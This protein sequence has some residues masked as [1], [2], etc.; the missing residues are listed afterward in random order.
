MNGTNNGGSDN[1]ANGRNYPN[2][3]DN[4]WHNQPGQPHPGQQTNQPGQ[5]QQPTQPGQYYSARPTQPTQPSQQ[6]PA[7]PGQPPHQW[8]HQPPTTPPATE[9]KKKT[10]L[11][12]IGALLA[13]L[14]L[15]IA[16]G[17]YVVTQTGIGQKLAEMSYIA[18]A[19]PGPEAFMDTVVNDDSAD[20]VQSAEIPEGRLAGGVDGS[21]DNLYGGTGELSTCDAAALL[22]HLNANDELNTAFAEGIGINADDVERYVNALSPLV[23]MQDTWVTNHGFNNGHA[24]PFQAVL[25]RGTAVLVDAKGVPRVR[26]ACGNPLAEAWN[27]YTA[28]S[29]NNTAWDGY[30]PGNVVAVYDAGE[31]QKQLKIRDL[32]TGSAEDYAISDDKIDAQTKVTDAVTDDTPKTVPSDMDVKPDEELLNTLGMKPAENGDARPTGGERF[33]TGN[34]SFDP[35]AEAKPE[36]KTTEVDAAAFETNPNIFYIPFEGQ[37]GWCLAK[38][39]TDDFS[40]LCSPKA[41]STDLKASFTGNSLDIAAA[42][43]SQVVYKTG[44]GRFESGSTAHPSGPGGLRGEPTYLKEG[45]SVTIR[46]FTCYNLSDRIR[47]EGPGSQFDAIDDD[48]LYIDESPEKVGATCGEVEITAS[49]RTVTVRVANGFVDC[50]EAMEIAEKYVNSPNDGTYGQRNIQTIDNWGCAYRSLRDS[51]E[52][53]WSGNCTS[54]DTGGTFVLQ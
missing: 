31:S 27:G 47:C 17:I 18:S 25:Q 15:A 3:W 34:G 49:R 41:L 44:S 5:P 12:K 38:H 36:E 37:R 40:L 11:L 23:L 24:N 7:Q 39:Y 4:Q 19:D 13:A 21:S 9:P 28:P 6:S 53:G 2:Q 29:T 32:E 43:I 33:Q 16:G 10:P 42:P 8:Q 1:N 52:L 48:G 50:E 20:I 45:E 14:V 30:T 46:D 26:C 51:E 54:S 22:D 35:E